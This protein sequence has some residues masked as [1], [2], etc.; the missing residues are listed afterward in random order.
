MEKMG[1]VL[2]FLNDGVR[3]YYELMPQGEK[4]SPSL[5][6]MTKPDPMRKLLRKNRTVPFFILQFAFSNFYLF[7]CI[8]FFLFLSNEAWKEMA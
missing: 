3:L 7:G 6:I 2:F 1:T 8:P 5:V 4:S